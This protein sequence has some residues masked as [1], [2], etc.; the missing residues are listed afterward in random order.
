MLPN[1]IY[2]IARFLDACIALA[3]LLSGRP[4]PWA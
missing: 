3:L 4:V 1:V 2:V